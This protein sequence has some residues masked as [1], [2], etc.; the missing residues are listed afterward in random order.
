MIP[1]I[2]RLAPFLVLLALPPSAAQARVYCCKDERGQQV[3]GDVLPASCAD[4]KY[5]E[6]N[7]QGATVNTVDAPL[8]EAQRTQRDAEARRN[9][10]I[11]RAANEQ[12]RRDATLLNTYASERDIDTAR[13]RRVADI[14]VLLRQLREQQQTL[15]ERKKSLDA[16]KARF[17]GK[18]LPGGL[19]DRVDTNAEDVR[20][21]TEQI[22]A[23]M[24]DLAETKSRFDTDLKRY[25]ELSG[26]R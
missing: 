19:K 21:I 15:L 26:M 18:P 10:E 7:K 20:L 4:R 16:A 23:R 5:R 9:A 2:L 17:T 14:E 22:A 24:A 8:T 6:L 12:R 13:D 1:P 11:E 25:R 3:C